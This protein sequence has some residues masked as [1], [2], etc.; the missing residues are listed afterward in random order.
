MHFYHDNNRK[1]CVI[2]HKG[3]KQYW[4]TTIYGRTSLYKMED[5]VFHEFNLYLSKLSE[6]EQD[7]L[8]QIYVELEDIVNSIFDAKKVLDRSELKVL[9]T[10]HHLI[11]KK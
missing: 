8:W 4:P 5:D 3:E 1:R 6:N 2:E 7:A 11:E 9:W 10:N